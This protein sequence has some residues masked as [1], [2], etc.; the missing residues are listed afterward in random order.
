LSGKKPG[1]SG[2]V[3]NPAAPVDMPVDE[4]QIIAERRGKLATLRK[5]GAATRLPRICMRITTSSI[6]TH[7]SRARSAYPSRDG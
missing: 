5:A 3:E 4:N 7:S 2:A 6:T 1:E